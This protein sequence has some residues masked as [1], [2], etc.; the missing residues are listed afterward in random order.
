MRMKGKKLCNFHYSQMEVVKRKNLEFHLKLWIFNERI[1]LLFK[2]P[3]PQIINRSIFLSPSGFL[4]SVK[5][6]SEDKF[7]STWKSAVK[8]PFQETSSK[9]HQFPFCLYTN[10]NSSFDEDSPSSVSV[11]H[12]RTRPKIDEKKLHRIEKYDYVCDDVW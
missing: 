6:L 1:T 10:L 9:R 4:P 2:V 7:P 12:E 8:F 11:A 3:R 5:S